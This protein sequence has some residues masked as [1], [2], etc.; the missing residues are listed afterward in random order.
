MT[1]ARGANLA[2]HVDRVVFDGVAPVSR[3]EL[4]AAISR[5][6]AGRD[7]AG[8][9]TAARVAAALAEHIDRARRE[10]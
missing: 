1:E 9:T 3:D 8:G 4:A 6:L 10:T 5:K 7:S 2:V